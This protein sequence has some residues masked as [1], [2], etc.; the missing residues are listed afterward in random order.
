MLKKSASFVLASLRSSSYRSVR[1]ASSLAATLLDSLFEHPSG[2]VLFLSKTCK[3]SKLSCA[4]MVS[5]QPANRVEP[6]C[7]DDVARDSPACS[8]GDIGVERGFF[9]LIRCLDL[10]EGK[11]SLVFLG[12]SKELESDSASA[13]RTDHRGH[14]KR[15]FTFAK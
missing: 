13:H 11:Q 4:V 8:G 5:L 12:G 14:F 10:E 2:G 7:V 9:L 6:Y 15:K 1:L 3:P